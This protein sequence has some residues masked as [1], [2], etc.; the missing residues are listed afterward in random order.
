MPFG[1]A[2]T[3]LPPIYGTRASVY[4]AVDDTRSAPANECL[5]AHP[6]ALFALST[7][8]TRLRAGGNRDNLMS[9]AVTKIIYETSLTAPV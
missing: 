5:R 2:P 1:I 3:T 9:Q 6:L 7:F 4:G 8:S